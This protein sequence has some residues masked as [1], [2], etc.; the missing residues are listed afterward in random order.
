MPPRIVLPPRSWVEVPADP[1]PVPPV[2]DVVAGVDSAV[3]SPSSL[4][5]IAW[6]V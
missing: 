3:S 6:A 1:P 5:A 4:R 2:V